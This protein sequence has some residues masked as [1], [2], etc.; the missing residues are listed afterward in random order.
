MMM[1]NK[2]IHFIALMLILISCNDT[3]EVQIVDLAFEEYLT[4]FE[5][6]A[7]A[8]SVDIDEGI[9]N[10]SIVFNDG[11]ED[12]VGQCVTFTDGHTEVRIDEETWSRYTATQRE[13]LV[14]HELGHCLLGREHN[15]EKQA[16]K[17]VSIMRESAS[18]CI[19]SFDESER[20][21]YLNELFK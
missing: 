13:I 9:E 6:E 2:S 20:E 18:T 16:G 15:N 12:V 8:R 10:L 19:I 3:P 1:K 7:N 14:F 5:M 11:S 21:D 4:S 17:C